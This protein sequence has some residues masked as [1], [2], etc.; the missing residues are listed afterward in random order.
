MLFAIRV[1]RVVEELVTLVSTPEIAVRID[2]VACSSL[3][4]VAKVPPPLNVS[5]ESRRVATPHTSDAKV[6]KEAPLPH[7]AAAEAEAIV[8]VE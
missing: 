3:A 6:P 4:D 5:S 1:P 2:D 8:D 7:T